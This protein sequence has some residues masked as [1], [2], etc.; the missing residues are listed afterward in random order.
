MLVVLLLFGS[1]QLQIWS[2]SLDLRGGP[3]LHATLATGFTLPLL[4]RRRPLAV[5]LVVLACSAAQGWLGGGLGQPWLALLIATYAVGSRG[6]TVEAAAG[7]AGLGGLILATDIPRLAQGV[8]V[9]DVVPAWF[10]VAGTFAFGRWMRFRRRDVTALHERAAAL[11]RDREEATQAAVAHEQARI[12]RELHD[13]VAHSLAI[14]VLQAQAGGR[15]VDTD[16]ER[17][18]AALGSIEHV[19]REGLVELR[20]LLDMLLVT[21]DTVAEPDSDGSRPSLTQLDRLGARV[22]DAGVPVEVQVEG[23]PRPLPPGLDL[24]A[25]R[26]VQE[27]LTNTLKHAGP[28]RATVRVRYLPDAVEVEVSDDGHA[29]AAP[30]GRVGHG[31]IG[32]HERTLLYGG[33]LLTG[34]APDGGFRVRARFPLVAA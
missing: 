31:L 17:A 33:H 6:S 20:R 13:L 9:D 12:A 18:R 2:G 28:A 5:L 34:Q 27:A 21:S 23:A 14:V 30:A 29:P 4:L 16:V 8:P 19:G 3:A 26:V 1:A 7:M 32:M 25:Y 15:V 10:V 24:S 22:S 11:E